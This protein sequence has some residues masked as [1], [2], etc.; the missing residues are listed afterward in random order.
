MLIYGNL[1]KFNSDYGY[2]YGDDD[3]DGYGHYVGHMYDDGD[4]GNVTGN[5]YGDNTDDVVT[6]HRKE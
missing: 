2:G 4:N 3:G 5:G 1:S 6:E